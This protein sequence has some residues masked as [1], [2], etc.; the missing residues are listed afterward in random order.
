ME[1]DLKQQVSTLI[2]TFNA[3]RVV[4]GEELEGVS[5]VLLTIL[6]ANKKAVDSLNA[7]T[8][9]QLQEAV[10]YITDKNGKILKAI[11]SDLTKSKAEI[12]KATKAQNDRAFK[13]LQEVIAAIR[14][15]KDG[16][17]GK[18]GLDGKDGKD[19]SPDSAEQ[20]RDKLE[21]LKDE[22]RLDASAIKNLPRWIERKGKE[23][24]V[25]GIRFLEQLADVSIIHTKKRQDLLVQYNTTN[26]RWQD[27]IAITVSTTPPSNPQINDLWVDIS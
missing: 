9:K 5:K 16:K 10:D 2:R 8:K 4:T 12:E 25:G 21:T 18:N 27:G 24:V 3:K 17:D 13:R 6:A 11:S 23:L 22:E 19:G 1:K 7:E 15:P 14:M 20:V 26:N